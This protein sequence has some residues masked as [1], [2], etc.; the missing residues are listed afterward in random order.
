MFRKEKMRSKLILSL[1][2]A[3]LLVAG[4]SCGTDKS[5][6]REERL[7]MPDLAGLDIEEA[8]EEYSFITIK[9]QDDAY[10]DDYDE[11][12]IIEQS[13]RPGKRI[14]EGQLVEVT[15]SRGEKKN[16]FKMMDFIGM[17]YN[18]AQSEYSNAIQF[19]VVGYENDD[20]ADEDT[21]VWQEIAPGT[22]YEKGV[23]LNV[24]LSSGQE[25]TRIPD[26]TNMDMEFA[27]EKLSEMGLQVEVKYQVASDV[28]GDCV[29]RTEPEE[30][31]QVNTGSTIIMYV[32]I[33]KGSE[34]VSVENWIGMDIV[35]AAQ[36][37]AYYGLNVRTECIDSDE[38][39]GTVIEQSIAEG[40]MVDEGT[41]IILY[42]SSG[43]GNE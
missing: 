13:V 40:E 8:E 22:E 31:Q 29:I 19:V 33:G 16:L 11:G 30:G 10:S 37:A 4:T 38:E 35:N 23:V 34:Q 41:E 1:T 21:I 25:N 12:E 32:S 43:S 15:I 9:E 3:A 27:K 18:E 14:E 20:N 42:Y 28:P 26:L 39:K 7:V 2:C 17:D 6:S 5:D 24:K 36:F